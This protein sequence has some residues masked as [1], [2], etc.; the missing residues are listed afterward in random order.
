MD[1][2][3]VLALAAPIIASVIGWWVKMLQSQIKELQVKLESKVDK[4]SYVRHTNN[5]SRKLDEI[6]DRVEDLRVKQAEVST[7]IEVLLTHNG[8]VPSKSS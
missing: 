1:W 5:V 3:S 7:K 2:Q 4:S 6:F 8:K